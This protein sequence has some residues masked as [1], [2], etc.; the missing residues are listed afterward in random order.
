M[1]IV[2]ESR[3]ISAFGQEIYFCHKTNNDYSRESPVLSMESMFFFFFV[4]DQIISNDSVNMMSRTL[5]YIYIY[6]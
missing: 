2:F 4:S 6:I 3:K 5:L 1:S